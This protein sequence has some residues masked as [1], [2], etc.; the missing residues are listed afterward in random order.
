M[1]IV[2][3]ALLALVVVAVVSIGVA[4]C[5]LSSKISREEE[6]RQFEEED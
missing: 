1:K 5:V 3:L 2:L 6:Q 4:C